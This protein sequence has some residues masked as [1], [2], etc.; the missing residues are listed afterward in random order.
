[1]E[2]TLRSSTL[3]VIS[4]YAYPGGQAGTREHHALTHSMNA[5][6]AGTW[7]RSSKHGTAHLVPGTVC[8]AEAGDRSICSHNSPHENIA[9]RLSEG[10]IDPD[11]PMHFKHTVL[12]IPAIV[13]MLERAVAAG[14]ADE[15]DSQ[16][17]ELFDWVSRTGKSGSR[18]RMQRVK[19]F[20]EHHALEEL[21]LGTIAD[22]VGLSPFVCLRQFKAAHGLTPYAYLMQ[23]RAVEARRLLRDRTIS[24]AEAAER[25]GFSDT[26]YFHRFFKRMSGLTPAQYRGR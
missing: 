15:F 9:V 16:V 25:T 21:T 24:I 12:A 1:M 4:R 17:F 3:A 10:A 26:S 8:L 6:V 2:Q 20:I 11:L 18:I 22:T 14:S 7:S 5:T 23:C 13:P 19:R